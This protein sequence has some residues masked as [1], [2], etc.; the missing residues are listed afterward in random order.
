MTLNV[1]N[2]SHFLSKHDKYMLPLSYTAAS[3]TIA[4]IM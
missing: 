4:I 2:F 3:V 1:T